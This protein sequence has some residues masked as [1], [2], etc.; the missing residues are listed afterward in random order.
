MVYSVVLLISMEDLSDEHLQS[1]QNKSGMLMVYN[2][3]L[4]IR[5]LF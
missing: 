1:Y 2:V 3:I 5:M 4:V